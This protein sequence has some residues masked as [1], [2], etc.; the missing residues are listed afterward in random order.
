MDEVMEGRH[1]TVW[2]VRAGRRGRWAS[3]FVRSGVAAIGWPDVGDVSG[4][5]RAEIVARVRARYGEK[6]AAGIAGMLYRFASEVAVGDLV[7]TPDSETREIHSGSV[8][9]GYRFTPDGPLDEL[10]NVRSVVWTRTFSR[11][12]L[13]KRILYQLGSL[14]TLSTPTSQE[15]LRAFLADGVVPQGAAAP[16]RL[17]DDE[18]ASETIDLYDEL[19]AQ[20]SELIQAQVA[21]LDGYQTQDLVAGIL[22][23]LGYHTQ[24]AP[25]GADGGVDVI[26][27]RDA[28]GIEPPILKVQVKARPNTRSNPTDVR[29]LAGLVTPPEERGLFVSTG[30]YTRDAENDARVVRISLIGMDRLVE[31]LIDTYDELDQDT[32]SLVPLRRL[33]VP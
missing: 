29:A 33:W 12:A 7:L 11:D 15:T 24:V 5:E 20:T 31:L 16:P 30:G 32:K 28:L 14:R 26:A 25:E 9:G 22:R 19:R 6:D 13:P 8:T 4:C 27:S 2:L 17:T 21:S 1:P 23:A 18:E 3:E 10:P